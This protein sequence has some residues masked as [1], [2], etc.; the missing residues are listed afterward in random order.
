MKRSRGVIQHNNVLPIR[1]VKR[2]SLVSHQVRVFNETEQNGFVEQ[3]EPQEEPQS[4]R[5]T[6]EAEALIFY[7]PFLG[8]NDIRKRRFAEMKYKGDIIRTDNA[9][10]MNDH[11][12]EWEEERDLPPSKLAIQGL[13]SYYTENTAPFGT[14]HVLRQRN[15]DHRCYKC[16]HTW[17]G[18]EQSRQ[19]PKCGH[20]QE[21]RKI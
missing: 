3:E 18:V 20:R 4:V 16:L 12:W 14:D 15:F 8:H 11:W 7:P 10:N 13:T 17:K 19:C 21:N 6:L 2:R 9:A 5:S 1:V